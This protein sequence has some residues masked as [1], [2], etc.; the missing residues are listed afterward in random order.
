MNEIELRK[1]ATCA[2]CRGKIMQSGLPLFYQVTIARHGIDVNAVR[3]QA[4]LGTFLGSPTLAS[5]MGPD[6][7]MTVTVM[8]PSTITVCE[9]CSTAKQ[10]C[11]AALAEVASSAAQSPVTDNASSRGNDL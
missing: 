2:L 7:Q 6:E 3:R 4:G 9:P 10:H 5:I 1:A 8:D 11:V